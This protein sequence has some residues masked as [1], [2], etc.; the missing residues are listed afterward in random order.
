[1]ENPLSISTISVKPTNVPLHIGHRSWCASGKVS[2][3]N[4]N[5]TACHNR[6]C[7]QSGFTS[8]QI[9][10]LIEILL[11]VNDP[12]RAKRRQ[13]T[14]GRS[15]EAKQLIPRCYVKDLPAVLMGSIG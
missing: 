15:I 12:I 8:Y 3:A 9:N 7:V 6:R 2:R 4:H 5:S 1:M 14:S 13:A 11:K 10:V